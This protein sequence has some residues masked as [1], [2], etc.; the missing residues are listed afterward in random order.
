M[1]GRIALGAAVRHPDRISRLILESASPGLE[2]EP[3]REAR[4][5]SDEALAARIESRGIEEF[6]DY[7]TGL[8]LFAT[9]EALS[10]EI[11]EAIRARRLRNRPEALA[12]CL[13]ALGAGSQPSLWNDLG[14][15]GAPTLVLAGS[16]DSKYGRIG[17]RMSKEIPD[18]TLALIPGAGHTTHLEAPGDWLGAVE[19]FLPY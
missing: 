16:E 6:V 4:Q 14:R 2:N 3:E 7:W 12:A 17:A 8:P 9:Q 19:G 13:R 1:G 18:A 15:I 5:Q 11:R 10:T